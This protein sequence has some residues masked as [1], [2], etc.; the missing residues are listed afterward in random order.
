MGSPNLE[1]MW[2]K[3]AL[4]VFRTE[5]RVPDE[6]P[7]TDIGG[8]HIDVNGHIF[9]YWKEL[10][11]KKYNGNNLHYNITVNNGKLQ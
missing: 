10:P 8:F 5:S 2:S 6:P 7:K 1:E 11:K 9:I 3:Y 4:I